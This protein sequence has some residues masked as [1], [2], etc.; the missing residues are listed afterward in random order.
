MA[1]TEAP[2][3]DL[4]K[5]RVMWMKWHLSDFTGMQNDRDV[6]STNLKGYSIRSDCNRRKVLHKE[7]NLESS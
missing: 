2:N 1:C 7:I 3:S 5:H 6:R 4:N